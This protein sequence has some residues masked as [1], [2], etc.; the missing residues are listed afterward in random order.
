MNCYHDNQTLCKIYTAKILNDFSNDRDITKTVFEF[1]SKFLPNNILTEAGQ[2]LKD[3]IIA[4]INSSIEEIKNRYRR[5]V[6]KDPKTTNVANTYTTFTT[7]IQKK[8]INDIQRILNH[9]VKITNDQKSKTAETSKPQGTQTS[10]Q[11]A[12]IANPPPEKTNNAV[13]TV[14]T[15]SENK[16]NNYNNL[17]NKKYSFHN[18]YESKNIG[19]LISKTAT[20]IV[21]NPENSELIL[22]EFIKQASKI[23]IVLNEADT[24]FVYGRPTLF[25]PETTQK[26]EL[27]NFGQ[28]VVSNLQNYISRILPNV[29]NDKKD[30]YKNLLNN[31]VKVVMAQLRTYFKSTIEEF[32]EK[33]IKTPHPDDE[34]KDTRYKKTLTANLDKNFKIILS[35]IGYNAENVLNQI[36]K[37]SSEGNLK[38]I[39]N[40]KKQLEDRIGSNP[41]LIN[42][43]NFV[44]NFFDN[45]IKKMQST[46]NTDT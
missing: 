31:L 41:K 22:N 29:P 8:L 33:S 7:H 39:Q 19:N 38:L 20:Q 36:N 40:F 34:S 9:A 11:T 26:Q 12:T 23:K 4:N 6:G 1:Y 16:I 2:T 44:V 13:Q 21:H 10:T 25:G 5:L 15:Q 17:Q 37:A 3:G 28:K 35:T 18:F 46:K 27:T 30:Y 43:K 14:A 45:L 32:G 42:N 24:Y